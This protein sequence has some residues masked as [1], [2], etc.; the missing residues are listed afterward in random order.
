MFF[1]C[2]PCCQQSC[3]AWSGEF[4]SFG[5]FSAK[6]YVQF[7]SL[8]IF[9]RTFPPVGGSGWCAADAP[10]F[11]VNV[12]FFQQYLS[13]QATNNVEWSIS[14]TPEE[15]AATV[16]VRCF[17]NNPPLLAAE[18]ESGNLAPTSCM[19]ENYTQAQCLDGSTVPAV[20]TSYRYRYIATN[21]LKTSSERE[22]DLLLLS[23]SQAV[24][25]TIEA[26]AIV[27]LAVQSPSADCPAED[28]VIDSGYTSTGMIQMTCAE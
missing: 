10:A 5:T 1:N 25:V 24:T 12:P 6:E 14:G 19:I 16:S 17:Q 3:E 18:L 28:S 20:A 13:G 21:S 11:D 15:I 22:N 9:Q 26:L 23:Q 7:K 4:C 27:T 2:L 8:F